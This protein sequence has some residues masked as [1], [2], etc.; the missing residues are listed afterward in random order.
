MSL[1]A[2]EHVGGK[3]R[4]LRLQHRRPVARV[5][6]AAGVVLQQLQLEER[7]PHLRVEITWHASAVVR[8]GDGCVL[9]VDESR[10]ELHLLDERAKEV[11]R[12]VPRPGFVLG[13]RRPCPAAPLSEG[14]RA[15]DI[16]VPARAR[17]SLD[18]EVRGG[19]GCCVV[20]PC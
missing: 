6:D 13:V 12:G 9:K 1:H 2:L 16:R 20:K 17:Q 19:L 11:V 15:H 4:R 3:E 10:D 18:M 7:E 5:V 8:A 14:G